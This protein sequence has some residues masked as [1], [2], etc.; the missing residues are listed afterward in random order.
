MLDF[1]FNWLKLSFRF[2]CHPYRRIFVI[3]N[4]IFDIVLLFA[5]NFGYSFMQN[6]K[7]ITDSDIKS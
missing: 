2:T 4:D 6:N 7:W 3:Y 5:L 1:T